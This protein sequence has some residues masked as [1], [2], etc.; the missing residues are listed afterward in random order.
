[1]NAWYD[2]TGAENADKCAWTFGTTFAS[3]GA[4]ANVQIGF[5]NYL[6]QQNWVNASGGYCG[7]SYNAPP[8]TP[9]FSLSVSP[10]SQ[11]V[12][13]GQTTGNYSVTL[14][15]LNGWSG[16]VN[17]SVPTALPAGAAAHVSGNLITI[18]T[19]AG[20]T[21]GGTYPFTISGTDGTL[22]HTTSAT[23]V[24]SVPPPPTFSIS[25]SPSS[26]SQ[27]RPQN[28]TASV[29]YTVT[30]T[31]GAGYSGTVNLTASGAT[32]GVTLG[33]SPASIPG[34]SGT[35]TLTATVTSSAK[36]GNR[37]L[38]VSGSD[39]QTIKSASATLQVN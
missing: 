29:D 2:S 22:T 35:S 38:T 9:D 30:L 6:I 3:N 34:G 17:Y 18:S 31:A 23:L 26:Q 10:G 1:L 4:Q 8:P 14:T 12:T 37:G 5:R 27:R 24:V 19:T 11:T 39:G 28:G 16:T 20:T 36:K 7:L 33:F 15:P 13:S 32:T 21:P 25:I